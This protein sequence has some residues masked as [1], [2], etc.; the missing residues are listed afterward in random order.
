MIK[1]VV[2]RRNHS[3]IIWEVA[4]TIICEPCSSRYI[5]GTVSCQNPARILLLSLAWG[6]E[7]VGR[8]L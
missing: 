1:N 5:L 8:G 7:S 2:A 3:R 4:L 6:T